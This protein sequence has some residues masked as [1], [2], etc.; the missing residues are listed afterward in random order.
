VSGLT[1][2]PVLRREL[3]ERMRGGRAYVV[4]TV[5]LGVLCGILY[6]VHQANQGSSSSRF[7]APAATQVASVGRGIFEWLLFFM[8]L[9]VLF[10]VPGQTSGA[11]AGE[12][13]RQTLV[14]LQVTLLRPVS[15]LVGKVGAALAFL[16]LLIVAT[17]PLLAVSYLIGGVSIAEVLSGVAMIAFTGVVLACISAAIS[18]FAK[19]VQAAT[20]MS[21]GVVLMLAIGTLLVWAAAGL[22]DTSRGVDDADPPEWVLWPNPIVAMADVLGGDDDAYGMTSSP[23][24]PIHDLLRRDDE[25]EGLDAGDGGVIVLPDG[26]FVEERGMAFDE[27]GN[28]IERQGDLGDSFWPVSCAFLATV[29]VVGLLLGARRLR[30]PAASER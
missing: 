14:P 12:R 21:Y 4:L 27:F 19:R 16:L 24:D 26:G 10:L 17:V 13:E 29:A 6:L 11:I 28:P 2:N 7:G 8:L 1:V 9:L 5:Y 22:V 15:L 30:T 20:V 3:L 23:F 25:A 18:A